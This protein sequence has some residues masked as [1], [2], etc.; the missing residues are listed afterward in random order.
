[1]EQPIE[2]KEIVYPDSNR[3]GKFNLQ[4]ELLRD[5]S[6]RP[7][8]QALFGLC[9]VLDT[10]GHESG[11]GKTY[12]AASDLFQPLAENEEVPEYRIEFACNQAFINPEHEA[13]RLNSGAF[14][15]VAVRQII[16]R[17]P[18]ASFTTHGKA[19]HQL[20]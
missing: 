13:R 18:A 5:G 2:K 7:M 19:P 11:R 8:L 1:M 17:V 10:E 14:G 4:H 6:A 16:V 20:H 9:V 3:I 15:F 12:F